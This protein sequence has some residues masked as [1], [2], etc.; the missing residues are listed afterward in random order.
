MPS[1]ESKAKR[2]TRRTMTQPKMTQRQ[3]LTAL[4]EAVGAERAALRASADAAKELTALQRSPRF[5]GGSFKTEAQDALDLR[6]GQAKLDQSEKNL[7][8]ASKARF[9]VEKQLA[10]IDGRTIG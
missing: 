10:K 8:N 5:P 9:E 6:R 2:R 4:G 1:L 7:T 3:A